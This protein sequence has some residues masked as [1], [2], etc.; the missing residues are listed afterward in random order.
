MD[1]DLVREVLDQLDLYGF[2]RPTNYEEERDRFLDAVADGEAYSPRYTYSVPVDA[3]EIAGMIDRLAVDGD[4]LG[5]RLAAALRGR[6]NLVTAIGSGDITAASTEVYGRPDDGV[7]A[8]ARD[9]FHP[10]RDAA[11]RSVAA[12]DL[13]EAVNR[14]F[15]RLNVDY[16]AETGSETRNDPAHRRI[17]VADHAYTPRQARRL[18]V[19]E[20][21]HAVRAVNGIDAGHP[22]L[23]YG[24]AGYE[25]MEEGLAT[26]NEEAVGVFEDSVPRITARVI[27]VDAADRSFHGLY[28]EMRELG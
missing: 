2:L 5:E 15:D 17:V 27:A 23:V 6:L 9:R 14:L 1:D 3:G 12:G 10:P 4:A 16:G 11:D 13:I 20:S 18:L 28:R 26:F 8:A 7:V 21:T 22:A 19:H 24:T 25:T